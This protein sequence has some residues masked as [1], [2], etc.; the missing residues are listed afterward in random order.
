M[1]KEKTDMDTEVLQKVLLQRLRELK[2]SNH[3]EI[4]RFP[5]VFKKLCRCFSISKNECWE[6]LWT[7]RDVGLIEVIPC[8]GI[9]IGE[10]MENRDSKN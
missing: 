1:T 6:V 9:K 10:V 2:E 7:L 3:S 8:H 5:M 4:V